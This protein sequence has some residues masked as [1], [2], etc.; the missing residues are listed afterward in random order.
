MAKI[1]EAGVPTIDGDNQFEGKESINLGPK[2]LIYIFLNKNL[3][4]GLLG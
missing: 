2:K 1:Y 4:I 3:K